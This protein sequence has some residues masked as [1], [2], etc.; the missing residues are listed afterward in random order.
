MNLGIIIDTREKRRLLFPDNLVI[1]NRTF[2]VVKTEKQLDIGDYQ[3]DFPNPAAIIERKGSIDELHQNLFTKDRV[4]FCKAL[5]RVKAAGIICYLFLDFEWW[6][7]VP[8]K[9]DSD[10]IMDALWDVVVRYD[11]RPLSWGDH[12]HAANRRKVGGYLMRL[13]WAHQQIVERASTADF[14]RASFDVGPENNKE[15]I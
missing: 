6:N 5:E 2:S 10:T 11:L 9:G 3:L 15:D 4:R 1:G 8:R 12:P 13:L 7:S 14:L